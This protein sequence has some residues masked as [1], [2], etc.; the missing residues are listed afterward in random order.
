MNKTKYQDKIDN[1]G[2]RIK[3]IMDDYRINQVQLGKEMGHTPGCIHMWIQNKRAMQIK[4]IYIF[5][6]VLNITPNKLFG[7]DEEEKI[8]IGSKMRET[9][10]QKGISNTKA[11][12]MMGISQPKLALWL[13]D[14]NEPS[15]EYIRLFC[16]VFDTTPN[17][18]MGFE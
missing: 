9:L 17:H 3:E 1:F 11:A 15:Q 2:S 10:K 5:C 12:K 18:L 16:K 8:T 13:S 7:F 6:E 14:K 4:D